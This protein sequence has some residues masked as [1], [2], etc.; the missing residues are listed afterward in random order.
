MVTLN[1]MIRK[2]LFILFAVCFSVTIKAQDSLVKPYIDYTQPNEYILEKVTI[3]GVTYVNKSNIIDLTGL[4]INQKITIPSS[5]ISN[6]INKLWQQNLFSEINIEY[7]KIYND[8]ISLNI[9][10]KEYPRLSKFKF[11]G[12]IS[13]SNIST[14]KEDLQLM[15]GMI[16]TQNL[17]K[18]RWFC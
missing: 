11:K 16:L 3:K 6:A 15:R 1:K 13:K 9:I 18:N 5:D 8:S 7:D 12:N 2:I 14:L 4:K 17:I 10:L